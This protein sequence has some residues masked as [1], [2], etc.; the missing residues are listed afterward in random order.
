MR[1]NKSQ[2]DS[3]FWI[4]Y[5][6]LMAGLMFVFLL[7]IGAVVVKYVLTQSDLTKAKADLISKEQNITKSQNELVSKEKILHDTFVSLDRAKSQN[8][9]LLST[10]ESINKELIVTNEQKNSFENMLGD[11]NKTID[12]LNQIL[13]QMAENLK[14]KDYEKSKLID[15]LNAKNE[16]FS[17]LE[18]DYNNTKNKISALTSVRDNVIQE[19]SKKIGNKANINPNSGV[20]SLPDS[21]LFDFA[22]WQLKE[23]SKEQLKQIL[24]TYFDAIFSS[25]EILKHIDKIVIEGHTNSIGSYLYNL[26]LSQKRAYEVLKFIH[27]WNKDKRLEKY[28]MASGRSFNDLI[29]KDGVEDANASKR[30]EIRFL[31]SDKESKQ[32]IEKFLEQQDRNHSKN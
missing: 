7:I 11:A 9:Q 2:N 26:D 15:S 19:L 28:L 32:E 12:E 10:N 18:R 30:I 27:S 20:I 5:A 17:R 8:E 23:E 4:S 14:Q 3:T 21:V 29:I 1:N 13:I 31:I 16:A 25:N 24:Q 6:D 22:S